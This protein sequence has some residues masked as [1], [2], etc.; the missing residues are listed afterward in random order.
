MIRSGIDN[1]NSLQLTNTVICATFCEWDR[2]S[3]PGWSVLHWIHAN[4]NAS[5][6]SI[7]GKSSR[8]L[9]QKF[10]K[11]DTRLFCMYHASN[12]HTSAMQGVHIQS[13]TIGVKL[14]VASIPSLTDVHKAVVRV[15]AAGP[16]TVKC[17]GDQR[18][19]T[20]DKP[21]VVMVSHDREKSGDTTRIGSICWD[22]PCS[23]VRDI[24]IRYTVRIGQ[25]GSGLSGYVGNVNYGYF[26]CKY[27]MK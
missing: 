6:T 12:L 18:G 8:A 19:V 23:N 20:G 21:G 2:P 25:Q 27:G 1:N 4:C 16:W 17:Q 22:I 3:W 11:L 26:V 14:S 24:Y 15:Y 7:E 5:C 10:D 9:E 13:Y